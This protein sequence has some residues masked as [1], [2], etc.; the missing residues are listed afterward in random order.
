MLCCASYSTGGAGAAFFFSDA[1]Y[2][3]FVA[4]LQ[5]HTSVLCVIPLCLYRCI[6]GLFSG[7]EEDRYEVTAEAEAGLQDR[8][9]GDLG[10]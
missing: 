4:L 7:C 2:G 6:R 9:A 10:R 8:P 1:R 3:S 5:H